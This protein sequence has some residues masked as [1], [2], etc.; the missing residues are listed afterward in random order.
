[1]IRK[2][3]TLACFFFLGCTTTGVLE[4]SLST[5]D[6]IKGLK[7]AL[8]VGSINSVV[9]VNKLDGYFGNPLLKIPFP[10]EVANVETTLRSVGLGNLVD[11][12]VLAINRAAEDAAIKAKPIFLDAIT[13]MTFDDALKILKGDTIAATTYLKSK[14]FT[15]LTTAFKPSIQ[16]SLDKVDA[17]KYWTDL[18]TAYNKIP[19][20]KPINTDLAAYV[21]GKALDGLFLLVSKEE[22]K[23]RKDPVAR[24]SD[25]LK[26]VFAKQ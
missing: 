24:V 8:N 17:T 11:N 14:T 19:F 23:I 15:N 18:T 6:I 9:A 10:P 5:D 4:D 21:T 22:V 3:I 20:V 1:M 13:N 16:S 25:I 7:E 2:T 12:A 26:K